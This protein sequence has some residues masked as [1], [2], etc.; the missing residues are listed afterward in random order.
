VKR[1]NISS[2]TPWEST[3]GYSRAVRMG[4]HIWVAGTT[5]TDENGA[6]MTTPP[7]RLI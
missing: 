3:I 5:A 6:V 7:P 1:F 2:S 4:D